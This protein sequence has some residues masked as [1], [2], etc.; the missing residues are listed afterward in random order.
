M[1]HPVS[2]EPHPAQERCHDQRQPEQSADGELGAGHFGYL[3]SFINAPLAH[4]Q[5]KK[6]AM[7]NRTTSRTFTLN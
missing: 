2:L 4:R 5:P 1:S 6:K 3:A 7:W